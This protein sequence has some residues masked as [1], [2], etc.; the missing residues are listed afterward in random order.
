MVTIRTQVNLADLSTMRLGG[1]AAYVCDIT[2]RFEV[3]NALEWA[4]K[5]NLPVLMIGGGSN[6][7]WKDEGFK[8]L[9]ML[10]KITGIETVVEDA[11][12]TYLAV[13]SG[14]EWDDVV[15][16]SVDLG[17]CDLAPLSL[18]PGT[19]G[20]TPIQ[21]V[22]AYGV[23]ISHSLVSVEAYDRQLKKFITIPS[24]ECGFSYRTSRF[25]SSDKDRFFITGISLHLTKHKLEPPF[26]TA[27]Q[28]Y[29]TE[30]GVSDFTGPVVRQSVIALRSLKLPD[31][32]QVA[33]CGS[34]FGNP[35][36][37]QIQLEEILNTYPSLKYWPCNDGT[38]KVSAGWLLENAGFKGLHDKPTGMAIWEHHALVV[39]N[40][41]ASTTK[42]LLNF[43]EKVKQKI[44]TEYNIELIEEPQILP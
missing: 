8:G 34:F 22:G 36:I 41:R 15:K 24:F 3:P 4:E 7:V 25:K 31:P 10:N 20:A 2:N 26:Y 12:N 40:E 21:N 1:T 35:I 37:D 33:N 6:V 39:V 11:D 17:Y 29:F 42:D 30:H 5:Q 38:Y 43:V 13:G 9:L 23:D 27:L 44:R 28:H 32:K 16:T 14:E 19:A 18:I